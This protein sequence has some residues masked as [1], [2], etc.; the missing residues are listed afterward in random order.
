M[1]MVIKA[2]YGQNIMQ[3]VESCACTTQ[4]KMVKMEV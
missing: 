2:G 3:M 4:I 1:K